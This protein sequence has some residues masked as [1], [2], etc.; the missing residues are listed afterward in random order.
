MLPSLSGRFP[1][2]GI[3]SIEWYNS[4]GDIFAGHF[5]AQ[6]VHFLMPGK[7]IQGKGIL[8]TVLNTS[9]RFKPRD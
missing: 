5:V 6:K 8:P 2:D 7:F 3:A 9:G 4:L 1:P